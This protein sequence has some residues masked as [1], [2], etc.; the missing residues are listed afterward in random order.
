MI[1]IFPSPKQFVLSRN[2]LPTTT[3]ADQNA[4]ATIKYKQLDYSKRHHKPVS[5]GFS[6]QSRRRPVR[7]RE[8]SQLQWRKNSTKWSV[9]IK[10]TYPSCFELNSTKVETHCR[11][12]IQTFSIQRDAQIPNFLKTPA[13]QNRPELHNMVTQGIVTVK[14]FRCVIYWRDTPRPPHVLFYYPLHA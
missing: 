14:R 13:M 3:S 1:A 10:V 6:T 8:I 9:T 12:T 4:N 2:T 11:Y 5:D 7:R